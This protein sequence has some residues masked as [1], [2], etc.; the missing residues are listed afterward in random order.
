M[1]GRPRGR[2]LEAFLATAPQPA[3]AR[4]LSLRGL[5]E[6]VRLEL[7][8]VIGRR[9]GEQAR[10]RVSDMHTYVDR[11]RSERAGSLMDLDLRRLDPSGQAD[12][13][14]FAR[15]AF[16]RARLAYADPSSE[17]QLDRW[18]LRVFGLRG[19]LDFTKLR[20]RWLRETAK[21]WAAA[22]LLAP[23][24]PAKVTTV[25]HEL[26][27]LGLMSKVLASSPGGGHDPGALGRPEIGRFLARVRT[28]TSSRSGQ[29]YGPHHAAMIVQDC[30]R[31]LRESREMGLLA[32]VPV[33]F[34]IRRGE[35]R[36]RVPPDEGRTKK[37]GRCRVTSSP[38]STPT[39]T[40]WRGPPAL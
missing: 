17:Q 10:T 5:P 7:L 1:H 30:A 38:S 23:V 34:A 27:S 26:H 12:Q 4:V 19:G 37:A 2:R 28:F 35:E 29:P 14:R 9:R 8:Y 33:T 32:D 20:Q 16:D 22:R 31:V 39:S 11:L 25:Q 40:S 6:L 18:D 15:F 36:R 3:S 21:S 24:F 13:W